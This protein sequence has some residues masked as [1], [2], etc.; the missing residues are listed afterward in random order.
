MENETFK[1]IISGT[2]KEDK[3]IHI[4]IGQPSEGVSRI[5]DIEQIRSFLCGALSLSI[6]AS[7]NQGK[8]MRETI[9][10]LENEFVN[11]DSFKDMGVEEKFRVDEE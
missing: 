1:I 7:K 11:P 6:R 10:H 5:L 8:A 2:I 3:R 4:D 9:E